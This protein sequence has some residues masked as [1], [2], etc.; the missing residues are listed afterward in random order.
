MDTIG[1]PDPDIQ[2]DESLSPSGQSGQP[3]R[4][5]SRGLTGRLVRRLPRIVLLW[6]VVSMPGVYLVYWLIE[7]IYES[8]CVIRIEPSPD[9]FGSSAK[10]V[11][12]TGFGQYL[13][14]QRALILSNRVLEPAVAPVVQSPAYRPS[15]FPSIKD[16][17]DPKAVVRKGLRVD[18]IP[19]TF[20]IQVTFG[21]PSAIEAAEVVN[22]VVSAFEQQ[23]KEFNVGMNAVFRTN[24]DSYLQK[25]DRNIKDKQAEVIALAERLERQASK[26]TGKVDKPRAE[27]G[28][29]TQPMSRVDELQIE[30]IKDE[31]TNL[32]S[33]RDVVR[34]KLEQLQFES[35]KGVARVEVVD[36]ASASRTPLN[37]R[38]ELWMM[39][40][41]LAVFVVLLGFFLVFDAGFPIRRSA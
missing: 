22:Q 32:N 30:F 7:P 10:G 15:S 6:L 17:A 14:T 21:S 36:T 16:S 5:R 18:V 24:Y 20:L 26:S 9:L 2:Y 11:E 3:S 35:Q 4:D 28:D 39:M 40:L 41:P 38:R 29:I 19:G 33:M 12:T 8:S 23:N 31:L 25:L 34:R 13:D 27:E 37:D 1:G